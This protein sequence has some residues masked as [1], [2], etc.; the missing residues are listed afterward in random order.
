MESAP[1]PGP[2]PAVQPMAA[3]LEGVDDSPT[4]PDVGTTFL[5]LEV[6]VH[7]VCDAEKK[8]QA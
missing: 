1:P 6:A 8:K 4:S 3:K 2:P 5:D 7:A